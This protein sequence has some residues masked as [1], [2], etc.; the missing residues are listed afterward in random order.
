MALGQGTMSYWLKQRGLLKKSFRIRF[1]LA[2]W[3]AERLSEW[4]LYLP[5]DTE[6]SLSSRESESPA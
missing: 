5:K 1:T 2:F 6:E 4:V 3:K